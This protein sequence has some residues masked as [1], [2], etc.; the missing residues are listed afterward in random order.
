MRCRSFSTTTMAVALMLFCFSSTSFAQDVE[1]RLPSEI[2]EYPTGLAVGLVK[3]FGPTGLTFAWRD[4]ARD[5]ITAAAAGKLSSKTLH[6]HVDY[7]LNLV[8]LDDPN[9]P[10]V[11]FPLY[12]GLGLR[13]RLSEEESRGTTSDPV[14]GIRIPIGIAILPPAWPIDGFFEFA[15]VIGIQK[16]FSADDERRYRTADFALG[17]R[18]YFR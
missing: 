12:T 4:D 2:E 1:F 15:P 13:M 3:M 5:S 9:A 16:K 18:Y 10:D 11:A 7:Q 17:A 14:F 6:V 8:S